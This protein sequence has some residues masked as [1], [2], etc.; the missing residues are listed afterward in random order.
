MFGV[1]E[2]DKSVGYKSAATYATMGD[3]VG[4]FDTSTTAS[5]RTAEHSSGESR[6]GLE[7][8]HHIMKGMG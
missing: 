4:R 5:Q 3:V 8:R 7:E 6:W 2:G 1:G